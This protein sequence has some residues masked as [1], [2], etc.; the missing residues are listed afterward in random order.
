MVTFSS[1]LCYD[2]YV[3]KYK[4]CN[5]CVTVQIVETV[6]NDIDFRRE[7]NMKRF[8]KITCGCLAAAMIAAPLASAPLTAQA[9]APKLNKSSAAMTVGK[10]MTLKVQNIKKGTAIQWSSSKKAVAA[11]SSKG[12]VTA[13]SAGKATIKAVVNKKTLKCKITVKEQ[14]EPDSDSNLEAQDI[15]ALLAG[16][17][18]KG[19][20]DTPAGNIEVLNISFHDDGTASGS[21][22]NETTMMSEEFSGTY[23]AVLKDKTAVITVESDGNTM[24]EQLTAESE[25]FTKFS[26]DKKI[27]GIDI[28]IIVEEIKEA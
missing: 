28:S 3:T 2:K 5:G 25:D 14:T 15:S 1:D 19:T 27:M 20:A 13:K 12:V 6:A 4:K 9:A 16:K 22:I 7:T 8:R 24:T 18:Y 11:V 26:A 21:K 10:K 23:K 17:T